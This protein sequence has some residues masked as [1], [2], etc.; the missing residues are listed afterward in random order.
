MRKAA[1][2]FFTSLTLEVLQFVLAVGASDITDLLGN[3]AGG[4]LGVGIFY[5]FSKICKERAEFVLNVIALAGAAGMSLL[6]G[7]LLLLN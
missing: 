1:P 5:I 3:T 4:I 7:M 2:S 6:L